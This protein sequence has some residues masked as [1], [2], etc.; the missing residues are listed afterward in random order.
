MIDFACKKFD[1]DE[2]IRCSLILTKTEF[3]IIKY[4][5]KNSESK[6]TAQKISKIFNIGLSTSQK[7]IKK[8]YSGGLVKR[9]QKNIQKGGYIFEYSIKEKLILKRKILE[10]IHIWMNKVEKE[11]QTW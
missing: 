10:I 8:I 9:N 2:V 1:L 5:I 11:M 4:L 3:N 6:F 7:A